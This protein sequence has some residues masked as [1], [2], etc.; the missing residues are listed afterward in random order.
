MLDPLGQIG[1]ATA[2]AYL[3]P[4]PVR[5]NVRPLLTR[6]LRSADRPSALLTTEDHLALLVLQEAEEIDLT[7]PD[8]MALVSCGGYDV[9]AHTRVPLTSVVQPAAELGDQVAH[10][11]LDHIAGRASTVRQ[12]TLPISLVV[13]RSCGAVRD[14]TL[15]EVPR[16]LV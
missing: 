16:L 14:K 15:L 5:F 10:L 1:A 7:I 2:S 12:V 9:G 6:Y 8:D 4:S 11:V 3:P 13:R